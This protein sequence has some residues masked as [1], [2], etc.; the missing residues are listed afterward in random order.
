M[1]QILLVYSLLKETATTI[2]MIYK[3][4]QVMVNSQ[5]GDTDF[6]NIV[7]GVL[8]GDISALYLFICCQDYVIWTFIDLI[9]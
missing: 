4:K 1:E 3:S 2:I 6:I 5:A 8:Q 7:A 9:K